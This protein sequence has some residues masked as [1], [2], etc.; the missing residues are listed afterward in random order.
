MGDAVGIEL[1][2]L[3]VEVRHR[4]GGLA[5]SMPEACD[6]VVMTA[7]RFWPERAMADIARKGCERKALDAL[8][9]I[10]AKVREDLEARWGDDRNTVAAIDGL[11]QTIVVDLANVWFSCVE[12]RIEMRRC[13]MLA[14][15]TARLG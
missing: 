5:L 10:W 11:V 7:L 3:L 13:I 8:P 9:V 2:G 1:T 15:L 14:R 12:S 6:E 4:V